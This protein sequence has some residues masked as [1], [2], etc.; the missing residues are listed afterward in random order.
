MTALRR[1]KS[2]VSTFSA[3]RSKVGLGGVGRRTLGILCLLVTV[4]L[5]T[6]SNFMA[7]VGSLVQM[8]K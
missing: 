1:T 6:L 7:S 5:W 4:F 2:N 8:G 3:W